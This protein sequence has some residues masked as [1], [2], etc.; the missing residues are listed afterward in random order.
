[1]KLPDHTPYAVHLTLPTCVTSD[2]ASCTGQS[3]AFHCFGD[4]NRWAQQLATE[5]RHPARVAVTFG[6]TCC[7]VYSGDGQGNVQ[8]VWDAVDAAPAG[9]AL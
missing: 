6:G 2:R 1:M 9:G 3:A 8:S 4:A 5:A 7:A